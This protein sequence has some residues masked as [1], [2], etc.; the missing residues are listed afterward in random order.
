M[1]FIER[2]ERNC[3][4]QISAEQMSRPPLPAETEEDIEKYAVLDQSRDGT[5]WKLIITGVDISRAHNILR[6][7]V[8]FIEKK[9]AT[10]EATRSA[11]S[12]P[13]TQLKSFDSETS[14]TIQRRRSR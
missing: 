4:V 7:N 9:L 2:C 6:K 14:S 12:T 1:H 13:T 10:D 11:Q 5:V 3:S 8:N